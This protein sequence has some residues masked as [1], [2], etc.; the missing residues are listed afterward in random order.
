MSWSLMGVKGLKKQ[1]KI[2]STFL[3]LLLGYSMV[4]SLSIQ[5]KIKLL[6]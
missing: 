5:V 4:L 6:V 2:Q 3:T 1:I